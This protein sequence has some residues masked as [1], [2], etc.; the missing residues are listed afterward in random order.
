M[1]SIMMKEV[2]NEKYVNIY[3]AKAEEAVDNVT[4][5]IYRGIYLSYGAYKKLTWYI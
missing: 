4:D 3:F 2:Y 1:L 5:R